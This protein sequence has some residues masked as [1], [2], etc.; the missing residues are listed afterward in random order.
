MI[1][2]LAR[3]RHDLRTPVNHILGYAELLLEDATEH[4]LESLLPS[5]QRIQSGGRQL[6][7]TIETELAGQTAIEV[8]WDLFRQHLG[9]GASEVLAICK[10]LIEEV[11]NEDA[12]TGA[13]VD[14][15]SRALHRLVEFSVEGVLHP[16]EHV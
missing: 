8:D 12:Q 15:I 10:V 7:D 4:H 3:L 16:V 6:L 5:L 2:S 9:N 11:K 13:D 14:A 1:E